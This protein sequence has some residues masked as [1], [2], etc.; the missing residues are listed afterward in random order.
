MIKN[1]TFRTA[2]EPITQPPPIQAPE[3]GPEQEGPTIVAVV[4]I[5]TVFDLF[6]VLSMLDSLRTETENDDE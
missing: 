6:L 1:F 3:A 4:P 5:T 2:K